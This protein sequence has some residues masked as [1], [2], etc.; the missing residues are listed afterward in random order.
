MTAVINKTDKIKAEGM[1]VIVRSV[2]EKLLLKVVR[3]KDI[4]KYSCADIQRLFK[5][6]Q[7]FFIEF[8]L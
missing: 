5:I 8:S 6:L 7:G 2:L 4:D 3:D 1:S